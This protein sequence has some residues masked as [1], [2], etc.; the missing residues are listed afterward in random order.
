[1]PFA[2][3]RGE[4]H[5]KLQTLFSAVES[6]LDDF[7]DSS[8]VLKQYYIEYIRIFEFIICDVD[9]CWRNF[10]TFLFAF[11]YPY[12]NLVF[13]FSSTFANF[14]KSPVLRDDIARFLL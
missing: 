14:G 8:S 6:H 7:I 12:V 11:F 9:T 3:L 10:F 13:Q 1:M 2:S 4:K 5:D